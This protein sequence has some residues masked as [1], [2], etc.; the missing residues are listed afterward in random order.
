MEARELQAGGR[1]DAR[2]GRSPSP[3]RS[4][5]GSCAPTPYL[6]TP[7]SGSSCYAEIRHAVS[8]TRCKLEASV[9]EDNDLAAIDPTPSS[10]PDV[11]TKADHVVYRASDY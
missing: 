1:D 8:A 9:T 6:A 10:R 2:A 7:T 5:D 11:P 3:A 4:V